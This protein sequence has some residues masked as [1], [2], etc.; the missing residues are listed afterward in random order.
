MS[1]VARC[2]IACTSAN[3]WHGLSTSWM[4]GITIVGWPLDT[5]LCAGG[6]ELK[7]EDANCCDFGL[8]LGTWS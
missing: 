2:S 1:D 7:P 5:V 4:S 6:Q 8:N 3:G